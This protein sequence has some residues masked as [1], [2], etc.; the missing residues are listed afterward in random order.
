MSDLSNQTT[1]LGSNGAIPLFYL[2]LKDEDKLQGRL[3]WD[4]FSSALV[5]TLTH[6]NLWNHDTQV[7]SE[8]CTK[9]AI[10][11]NLTSEVKAKVRECATATDIWVTLKQEFSNRNIDL[12]FAALHDLIS[13][14]PSNPMDT[15]F[16]EHAKL[17]R[18]IIASFGQE[19]K[20]NDLCDLLF[21]CYLPKE[22]SAIRLQVMNKE[23][24]DLE[25]KERAMDFGDLQKK[26][27]SEY[28]LNQ[29]QGRGQK[30][31]SAKLANA[32][33]TTFCPHDHN[34]N[35]CYRC[36]PCTSCQEKQLNPFHAVNG[37]RCSIGKSKGNG[38]EAKSLKIANAKK[39]V[40]FHADSGCTDSLISNKDVLTLYSTSQSHVVETANGGTMNVEGMG[41]MP[42]LTVQGQRAMLSDVL[43][44]PTLTSNLLSIS[45]LDEKGYASIFVNGKFHVLS[46]R[47]VSGFIKSN[48]KNVVITGSKSAGLYSVSFEIDSVPDTSL[49]RAFLSKIA[50]RSYKEWHDCF[51]HLNKTDLSRLPRMVD[52]MEITSDQAPTCIPCIVGKS[53]LDPYPVSK[54]VVTRNAELISTD[55]WGPVSVPSHE[56]CHYFLS[57]VDHYSGKSWV[58]PFTRKAEIQQLTKD[59]I[60][61]IYNQCGRNIG[62]LR[63]DQGSNYQATSLRNILKERGIQLEMAA[64][65]AH[66][67]NGRAERLNY[68][69]LDDVRC[70]L[71][72]SNLDHGYW[73]EALLHANYT[74]N[75]APTAGR[76][77][78]PNHIWYNAKPDVS[79]L[80]AF[81]QICFPHIMTKHQKTKL[82]PRA[83]QAIFTGYDETTKAYRC[84]DPQTLSL[85]LSPS[86]KF[87]KGYKWPKRT[88]PRFGEE[89]KLTVPKK[90]SFSL[91]TPE[92]KKNS[93]PM[94]SGLNQISPI[95]FLQ[96]DETN[97][98]DDTNNPVI[99]NISDNAD[100]TNEFPA[101]VSNESLA[102]NPL[103]ESS[104]GSQTE[105]PTASSNNLETGNL[106]LVSSNNLEARNPAQDSSSAMHPTP[107]DFN[108]PGGFPKFD[109]SAV[110]SGNIIGSADAPRM[111]RSTALMASGKVSMIMEP[112]RHY[113]QIAG[114]PDQSEW[115][116]S[117]K[118]EFDGLVGHGFGTLVPRPPHKQILPGNWVFTRKASGL[119]KA[120]WTLRGDLQK[121]VGNTFAPVAENASFKVF[122]TI[123]AVEDLD[124]EQV[125]VVQAFLL[126]P[127]PGEVYVAQ[128]EGFVITGKENWVYKLNKAV[129]GLRESPR[130]WND[131]LD[132]YLKSLGFVPSVADACIYSREKNGS[133]MLLY[134]HVDDIAIAGRGD[135]IKVLK[136]L[137]DSKFGI[138]DLGPLKA[139]TSYQVTRDRRMRTIT[140][141]Q[142][143][144]IKEVLNFTNMTH[145]TP[146][147][148]ISQEFN[149][150]SKKDCP[151][152]KEQQADMEL[153][154][155]RQ[156][157]GSLLH[158]ANRTRPDIAHAV[159]VAARFSHNPGRVHWNALKNLL[160]YLK[161]TSTHGIILGGSNLQLIGYVDA[162]FAQC[163]DTRR[164]TTGF[165]CLW[166]KSSIT[167]K[168][169]LQ[170]SVTTSSC[171]AE[172]TGIY[173]AS[174]EIVWL[175]RLLESLGYSQNGATV[176][177]ADNQSSIKYAESKEL[178]GRMKHIDVKT[179]FVRDKIV[180]GTVKLQF[181]PSKENRADILT[182]V[183]PREIF[184]THKTNIGLRDS[185]RG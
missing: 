21:L 39:A 153:V 116:E 22:Y 35:S 83:S 84:V 78:V 120:R 14:R 63:T 88:Y 64:V 168:S 125:D 27:I 30:P 112:P 49:P 162:N 109:R 74:R 25:R 85:I 96:P 5:D 24:S 129:Y 11:Q 62:T 87:I 18:A 66:Q 8:K 9:M 3:N 142:N 37:P 101:N 20:S 71:A 100:V 68:T 111:T 76:D 23:R 57:F 118:R 113:R 69:L 13:F 150:L 92:P 98:S 159:G 58:F 26:I 170:P 134:V 106:P 144:Y 103:E 31:S 147:I 90:V 135:Q 6:Y 33:T 151:A 173:H 38:K 177:H 46:E 154:P 91:P 47:F 141:Y 160:R 122:C 15:A 82:D 4:D 121:E 123:A 127:H 43:H 81:G 152:T 70:L 132:A 158:I 53:K 148:A 131:E 19:I 140:L 42:F 34:P 110:S 126:A 164:S 72:Q 172:L 117:M 105:Q 55:W 95:Q 52:G 29:E 167:W 165:I 133:R 56:G 45:K 184:Q 44:V 107:P 67:Q 28:K 54:R 41:I 75:L 114:R 155:Y 86:V 97:I 124:L 48:E 79:H 65:D 156:V 77:K 175:R 179:L 93:V 161:A 36:N 16:S 176:L 157:V 180:D 137:L 10:L 12:Q 51:N 104:L 130:L 149:H 17:R 108:M 115:Y 59:F 183:V 61:Y 182:K 178:H 32:T 128:P 169:K 102:P 171:E 136:G 119:A 185:I 40:V 99:R 89:Q 60:Q 166:G 138:K 73:V 143:D 80:H 145:S 146:L 163:V 181:T 139:F 50:K 7:P 94:A 2:A 174:S 1:V